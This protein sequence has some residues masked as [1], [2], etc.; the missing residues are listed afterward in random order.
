VDLPAFKIKGEGKFQGF[1]RERKKRTSSEAHR[2]RSG[3]GGEEKEQNPDI[4]TT[5][6]DGQRGAR[7]N[8]GGR[9]RTLRRNLDCQVKIKDKTSGALNPGTQTTSL[10]NPHS[11]RRPSD[12]NRKKQLPTKNTVLRKGKKK[13]H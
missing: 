9:S 11:L 8:T 10:R 1:I 5:Y 12:I 6:G 7:T 13:G 4:L 2:K 3:G